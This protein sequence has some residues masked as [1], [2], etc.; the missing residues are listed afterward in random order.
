ML[1]IG[2]VAALIWSGVAV[3]RRP[4]VAAP[5]TRYA[6]DPFYARYV[7]AGGIP[8]LSSARTPPR[9]LLLAREIVLSM[10]AGRPDVAAEL[11]RQ[12]ARIAIMAAD[13]GT[14]D[15]PEQRGW[16]KPAADDPRLTRCERKHYAQ[17][18]GRLTDR[19][20][21]NARAR[22]M[23]GVLTTAAAENLLAGPGDRYHGSNNLV[24]EFSHAILR[25][26][27]TV[28][29]ALHARVRAA[30][31]KAM[32]RNL[33]AGEYASTT[34]E[35]YWAVG[36]QFWFNTAPV[37]TFGHVRVLS[38]AD[39]RAYDSGLHA[40]LAQVYRGHRAA[41]DLFHDHPDRVPPGPLPKSTA[42]VC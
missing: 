21:W 38:D 14:L 20:Y 10:L 33:W 4:V 29:P 40:V 19:E 18:I 9:A 16:R 41:G 7:D 5:P 26:V 13:E 1:P 36:T 39:L 31:A 30:Y 24:H 3:A 2:L 17:R 6:T 35:E 42:E 11:R 22:G 34:F 25:A 15:I 8:I 28:D 12:G 27:A 23:G 32:A 37:A